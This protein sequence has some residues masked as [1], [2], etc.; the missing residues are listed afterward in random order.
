MPQEV[1]MDKAKMALAEVGE[2]NRKKQKLVK[3]LKFD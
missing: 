3:K 2:I 1:G